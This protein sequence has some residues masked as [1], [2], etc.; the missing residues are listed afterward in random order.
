MGWQASWLTGV[1]STEHCLFKGPWT[2][3]L[4]YHFLKRAQFSEN[5]D[6]NIGTQHFVN[7]KKLTFEIDDK[8]KR[9]RK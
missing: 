7:M 3:K 9:R 6:S 4:T 5:F 1:H 2:P 8:R